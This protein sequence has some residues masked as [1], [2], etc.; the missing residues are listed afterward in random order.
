MKRQIARLVVREPIKEQAVVGGL[1]T[2]HPQSL[3]VEGEDK[4]EGK[5]EDED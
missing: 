4:V 2:D 5:V 1:A 3:R